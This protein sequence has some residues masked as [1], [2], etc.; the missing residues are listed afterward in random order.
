MGFRTHCSSS[1]DQNANLK[2]NPCASYRG[3]PLPVE[4]Q[5]FVLEVGKE[6]YINSLYFYH[7]IIA[8]FVNTLKNS[9]NSQKMQINPPQY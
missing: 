7:A 5:I 8:S 3:M 1:G 9:G 6:S 4:I 2:C